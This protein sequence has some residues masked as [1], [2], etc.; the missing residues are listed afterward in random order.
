MKQRSVKFW[1]AF[2]VAMSL[3]VYARAGELRVTFI[4]N[5]AFHITDGETTLLSD[6]PYKS[7]VYGYMAYDSAE[8]PEVVDGL[9]L[10]THFH[11]D[12]FDAEA[13]EKTGFK[14]VAPLSITAKLEAGERA[15]DLDP[16]QPDSGADYEARYKD[17]HI[18]VFATPH[19]FAPEHFSYLVTWHGKRLYFVGDTE[20][21][22]F[23]LPLK[24]LDVAFVTP[25]LVRTMARQDLVLNAERVVLYHHKTDEEVSPFQDYLRLD[26]GASFT[27]GYGEDD[28]R[29]GRSLDQRGFAIVLDEAGPEPDRLVKT[30][31]G[32]RPDLERKNAFELIAAPPAVLSAGLPRSRAQE[33]LDRIRATGATAH[34][35]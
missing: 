23:L 33:G 26:Q 15:I 16:A 31:R 34:L 35:D 3:A 20:T 29:G 2:A 22:G 32:L 10:I 13:Y 25:W 5:E 18:E 1:I 21:P 8:V 28:A 30:L 7:G 11:G 17:I 6:F 14:I 9:S 27:V 24:N 4:G 12:H 19:R